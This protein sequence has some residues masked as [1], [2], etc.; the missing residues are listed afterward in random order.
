MT[1]CSR[2]QVT[3][4]ARHINLPPECHSRQAIQ[5]SLDH[6]DGMVSPSRGL[7]VDFLPVAPSSSGPVCHQVQQQI[8]LICVTSTRPPSM[9]SGYTQ[10]SMVGSGPL[11]L[12]T[13]SHLGQSGGEVVGLPVQENHPDFSVV[14]QHALV[15]G[16]NGHVELNPFVPA[17]TAQ[18]VDST[19]QSDSSQESVKSES[20][21]LAPRAS[22]IKEEGFSE[23]V[24]A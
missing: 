24:A 12:P 18:S 13:D 2:K 5:A 20:S 1:W 7:P 4:K 14:A 9:G 3:L 15:L 11:C 21:F 10:P 17:Q 22:A 8:A 23:T 16:P 6:S 19:I